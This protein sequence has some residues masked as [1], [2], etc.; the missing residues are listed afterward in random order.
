[1]IWKLSNWSASIEWELGCFHM[2]V[3]ALA[4][5]EGFVRTSL[6]TGTGHVKCVFQFFV[7]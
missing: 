6:V 1:M 7:K 4:R 2:K 3:I 5:G